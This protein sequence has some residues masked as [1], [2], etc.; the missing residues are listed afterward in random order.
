MGR[1]ASLLDLTPWLLFVCNGTWRIFARP[2]PVA[3]PRGFPLDLTP[4]LPGFF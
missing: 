4:W 2:D 1:G 3:S